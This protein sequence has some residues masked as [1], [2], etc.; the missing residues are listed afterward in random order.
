M[1]K[2]PSIWQELN[3]RPL[4][5]YSE[6]MCST[7]VL[8]PLPLLLNNI[9][10]LRLPQIHSDCLFRNETNHKEMETLKKNFLCRKEP[11]QHFSVKRFFGFALAVPI[12]ICILQC[13]NLQSGANEFIVLPCSVLNTT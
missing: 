8:Q 1:R 6:G 11:N 4:E 5:F 9:F 7:P 13:C 2:K 3:P 10:S 12:T